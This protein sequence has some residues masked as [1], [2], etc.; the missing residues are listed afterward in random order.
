MIK[1][2]MQLPP[3]TEEINP[4]NQ[5]DRNNTVVSWKDSITFRN[6]IITSETPLPNHRTTCNKQYEKKS[7]D[8]AFPSTWTW[9]SK[10][11]QQGLSITTTWVSNPMMRDSYWQFNRHTVINCC[12]HLSS[13]LSFKI[14]QDQV[15]RTANLRKSK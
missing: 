10:V 12:F 3:M 5:W 9:K 13:S 11:I 15:I 1:F 2:E 6:D 14:K 7:E 8:L 4:R